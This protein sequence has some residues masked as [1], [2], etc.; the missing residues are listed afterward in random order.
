MRPPLALRFWI[1]GFGSWI[2]DFGFWILE[3]YVAVLLVQILD[4]GFCNLGHVL[5]FTSNKNTEHADPGGQIVGS[6]TCKLP[7]L[8]FFSCC[9]K[10][11]ASVSMKSKSLLFPTPFPC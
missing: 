3:R 7:L 5:D 4:F 8:T 6:L 10:T 11:K 9:I 1:L 2:F